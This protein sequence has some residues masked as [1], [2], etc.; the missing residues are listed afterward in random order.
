[1]SL[2]SN[3][4]SRREKTMAG[5]SQTCFVIPLFDTI[6]DATVQ[7]YELARNDPN[8]Y[9]LGRM[10]R[11]DVVLVHMPGPGKAAA[12]SVASHIKLSYPGIEFALLVGICGGVPRRGDVG[13]TQPREDIFLGDVIISHGIIQYDLG[14]RLDHRSIRKNTLECNLSRSSPRIRSFVRLLKTWDDR[15]S[16][17]QRQYLCT[18]QNNVRLDI[19]YLGTDN[20]IL[21][22]PDYK[23]RRTCQCMR[24]VPE[25]ESHVD[26][27]RGGSDETPYIPFGRLASGDTVMSSAKDRDKIARHEQVLGFEMEGAG[28]W[29]N[30][31]CIL[32]KGVSD[33]ADSHK[34]DAWQFYAAASAAACMRAL[35][36]QSP[37]SNVALPSDLSQDYLGSGANLRKRGAEHS[38]V[39]NDTQQKEYLD[40]L[41]FPQ[42]QYRLNEILDP[43]DTTCAWVLERS[44][45]KSWMSSDDLVD[46]G[47][48][49]WVKGKPGA[50][51]STLMKYLFANAKKFDRDSIISSFFFHAQG[52]NLERSTVAEILNQDG[53][54]TWTTRDLKNLLSSVIQSL[55][56]RHVFLFI[57]ALDE[58]DQDEMSD[59]IA[60]L[61]HLGYS[62]NTCGVNLRI[63]LASRHYPQ[64]SIERGIKMI[65][66]HQQDHQGDLRKYVE[67]KLKGGKLKMIQE[68]KEEI[69]ARAA[70]VFLWV[71]LVVR[72]L[73]DAF[74]TGKVHAVRQRLDEIPDGLDELF[75]DMLTRDTHDIK[76][77]I[78]CLQLILF[79]HRRLS[80]DELYFA[81]MFANFDVVKRDGE[82]HTDSIIENFILNVSKGLVETTRGKSRTVHFIHESV[83]DFLLRRDGFSRLQAGPRKHSVGDV[84]SHLAQLC[85]RY[86]GQFKSVAADDIPRLHAY[87]RTAK[88][89]YKETEAPFLEYAIHSLLPHSNAAEGAGS[90][91]AVFLQSFALSFH[92]FK[93]IHNALEPYH[94]R[95]HK[96]KV[97]VLYILAELNLD[98]LV[99]LEL[100]RTP[101]EWIEMGRYHSPMG[102]AVYAGNVR[103]IRA[104]LGCGTTADAS[105]DNSLLEAEVIDRMKQFVVDS[106]QIRMRSKLSM[107]SFLVEYAI[108]RGHVAILK[109]LHATS[110][111]NL[112]QALNCGLVPLIYAVTCRK[113]ETL[114]FLLGAAGV[115]L[116]NPDNRDR[117]LAIAVKGGKRDMVNV[118]LSYSFH[119][120]LK[121][122][123]G[124]G[125]I[126][127][128]VTGN[129]A[130]ILRRL[131]G[132]G[133]NVAHRDKRGRD[134]LSHAA[135]QGKVEILWI[136][137]ESGMVDIDGKDNTGRTAFSWAAGPDSRTLQQL[138]EPKQ[139]WDQ[140]QNQVMLVLLST[141]KVDVNSKDND[142]WTPL[143][144]AVREDKPFDRQNPTFSGRE[145]RL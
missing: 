144:W 124:E 4:F 128:A 92:E 43:H 57:D 28:I 22:R 54:I 125:V 23:H 8:S 134:A 94:A 103:S 16:D 86:M 60:F 122:S 127:W 50:G 24:G 121:D 29:D 64:L 97:T 34:N 137:I 107:V 47:G 132:L 115:H 18:I 143:F 140:L 78:L 123:T 77:L 75:A 5:L 59:M 33:Y 27:R 88:R 39:T 56:N 120:H 6:Y 76:D 17:A 65:L 119:P 69:C 35:L 135:E 58:C 131:I 108:E 126:H 52:V 67:V 145:I 93:A 83:R 72:S 13:P 139:S 11:Y 102:A 41:T 49:F 21:F 98:H 46:H 63:C 104:L 12:S 20:D 36:D 32:V 81:V 48:F 91:Q 38:M 62:S 112:N 117:A 141:G 80:R 66:E 31:P 95:R 111:V 73:N 133:C 9:T 114:D 82:V 87:R 90:P 113:A 15:L 116:N 136:L 71:T 37:I 19:P 42:A 106:K 96:P 53:S 14:K 118:L 129:D 110:K 61:Q 1:M 99:R 55:T 142:Q 109:L 74:A 84:H 7:E 89:K 30:L 105:T 85:F 10:G 101:Q 100:E 138:S 51:K 79:A 45:F 44:E 26:R 40:L 130:S 2:S 25:D 68:I 70:G 3:G